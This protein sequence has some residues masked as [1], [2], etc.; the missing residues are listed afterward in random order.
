M[1]AV[2]RYSRSRNNLLPL[3]QFGVRSLWNGRRHRSAAFVD[4]GHHWDG[5]HR[6]CLTD[7]T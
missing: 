3:W 7:Q 2:C 5:A 1:V 6:S 4:A